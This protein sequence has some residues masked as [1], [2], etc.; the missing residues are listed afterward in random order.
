[1]VI[2]TQSHHLIMS[3]DDLRVGGFALKQGEGWV[4][5]TWLTKH[6]Q[7]RVFAQPLAPMTEWHAL[8]T[9]ATYIEQYLEGSLWLRQLS[10][11]A[12]K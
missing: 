5:T 9:I 1:M 8:I 3:T 10:L 12:A 2:D 4:V 7:K 6:T 11:S